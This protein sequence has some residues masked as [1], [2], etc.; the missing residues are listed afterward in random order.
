MDVN[1]LRK[2]GD[3]LARALDREGKPFFELRVQ[4]GRLLSHLESEQRVTAM[5]DRQLS[6]HE[7]A[8]FG[9]KEDLEKYP[10]AMNVLVK[11]NQNQKRNDKLTAT[12]LGSVISLVVIELAKLAFHGLK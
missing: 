6:L 5:H 9:D 8:L 4:L 11:I 12:V 3:E 10:G 2:I 7:R 1:E